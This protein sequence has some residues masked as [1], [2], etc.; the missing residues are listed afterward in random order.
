MHN[1]QSREAFEGARPP[2]TVL[3]SI[4]YGSYRS[5]RGL[6][7]LLV[8]I[9][10]PHA[11]W[12]QQTSNGEFLVGPITVTQ[13]VAGIKVNVIVSSFFRLESRQDG[14][15]LDARVEANLQ[16]L[17]SKFASIVDTFPLPRDN[18]RSYKPDN[19]VVDL[20][21]K[22][23]EA[24]G[25]TA[26]VKIAGKVDIWTC[27]ENP[28]PNSKVEWEMKKIGPIKTKVPVVKTWPGSPIKNKSASQPFEASIPVMLERVA[29]RSVRLVLGAP[30]VKLKG[31]YVFIT[32]GLLD[33]AGVNVNEEARK[34]LSKAIAPNDLVAA[35]PDEYASLN[36]VV[37]SAAFAEKNG[38]LTAT[39]SMS[40]KVP[41][42]KI[43]EFVQALVAHSGT[44]GK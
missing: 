6:W 31:Q 30:A 37:T 5:L 24:A 20:P 35:I 17:Q 10:L 16:D 12:A 7:A 39:A 22:A 44:Q 42:E 9:T 29:E 21:A 11:G 43:N 13:D 19:L 8:A 33:L 41:V 15:Y 3:A 4:C 23:L 1:E 38:K 34:A 2:A 14:L 36:P 40:A 32:N 18:C 25:S 28:I 27:L 26:V